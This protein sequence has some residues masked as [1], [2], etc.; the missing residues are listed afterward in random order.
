MLNS[1]SYPFSNTE[2]TKEKEEEEVPSISYFTLVSE[3]SKLEY[4][5]S[6]K[7]IIVQ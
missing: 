6:A 5:N 2:E 4:N 7:Y 1:R 3:K